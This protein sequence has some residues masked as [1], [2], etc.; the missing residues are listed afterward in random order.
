[1]RKSPFDERAFSF[2]NVPDYKF[3]APET[4]TEISY[5]TDLGHDLPLKPLPAIRA[6]CYD[7]GELIIIVLR[8]TVFDA[9][10]SVLKTILLRRF[11]RIKYAGYQN[12]K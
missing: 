12:P 11:Q 3:V 4:Q 1:M 2:A 5:T 7:V 6:P 10:K 8:T 9:M